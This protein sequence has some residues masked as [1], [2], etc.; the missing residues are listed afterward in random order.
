MK[1]QITV[2]RS[3]AM[4]VDAYDVMTHVPEEPEFVNSIFL[5][6]RRICASPG[7]IAPLVGVVTRG[8]R[9]FTDIYLAAV[10]IK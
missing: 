5:L 7:N 3:G 8:A 9:N 2:Q 6:I 1:I 4:T 10:L